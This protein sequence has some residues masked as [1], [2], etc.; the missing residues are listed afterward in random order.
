MGA[1]T[2]LPYGRSLTRSD[3]AALPDDGHRYEL[4]DGAL[5]VSPSPGRRHQRAVTR[6]WRLLDAAG[7]P[8]DEV[9][10]APYDVVLADDTVVQ[11]DVLVAVRADL[12][13][14]A[15]PL[16]PRLVVEVLSPSTRR[17]DL[18]LKRSR[19]AAA[20]I[21]SYWIVDPDSPS[22]LVLELKGEEYVEAQR[23]EGAQGVTVA[24]PFPATVVPAELVAD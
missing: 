23:A 8:H 11:P 2:T 14:G 13:R 16:V 1:V 6:T 9:L 10:V 7:S 19:Y 5:V 21:P 20:G 17:T 12:D 18:L 3:L 22:L 4:L 15:V 24:A